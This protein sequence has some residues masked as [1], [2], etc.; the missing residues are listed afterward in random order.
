MPRPIRLEYSGALYHVTCRTN[1]GEPVFGETA[2]AAHFLEELG[3]A[4]AKTGWR[5]H[6]WCLLPD[7]AHVVLETP[8]PNLVSGMKWWLG[9][10]TNRYN[11]R[12]GLSGHLFAGRY[13][14]V[15]VAPDGPF[16]LEACLHA[17]L[18]PA[19]AGL[20]PPGQVLTTSPAT[21]AA[22]CVQPPEQRPAWFVVERLFTAA[23]LAGDS[24][25]TRRAFADLIESRRTAPE[26]V[27]WRALRRGWCFGDEAFRAELLSRLRATVPDNRR[28]P[29]PPEAQVQLGRMLVAEEL[30]RRG[31]S[32]EELARRCKTDP[33]KVLIARRLRRETTLSLRWI[34]AALHMGSINTLR[35][36]LVAA[37]QWRTASAR[38]AS[39]APRRVVPRASRPNRAPHTPGPPTEPVTSQEARPT[40]DSGSKARSEPVRSEAGE[41]ETFSV[42]W[43]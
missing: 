18:N 36:C 11:R 22:W 37:G 6:A 30:A 4:C 2:A 17:L 43:D 34:A 41:P 1:R 3:A 40:V 32:A 9:T 10:F 31:W 25:E 23:G 12:R 8:Q 28:G 26:P 15:P 20:L 42:A 33:E 39:P 19:R 27:L 5:V 29:V 14:A 24:V 38:R 35:N 13:R 16:F 21:S 7:H